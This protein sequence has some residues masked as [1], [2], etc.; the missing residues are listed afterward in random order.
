M[1]PTFSPLAPRAAAGDAWRLHQ[2]SPHWRW[3]ARLG[4][5]LPI[6]AHRH[7]R[8]PI[9]CRRRSVARRCRSPISSIGSNQRWSASRFLTAAARWPPTRRALRA[10]AGRRARRIF[11]RTARSTSS[12]SGCR[13]SS[14]ASRRPR[15]TQAQGSG[16]VI[17][18][19]GFVVTNNHVIDGANKITVNFDQDTKYEA[20]LIGTDPRTDLALLKIKGGPGNFHVS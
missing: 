20:E 18:P 11:R 1:T 7:S 6:R 10:V 4:S 15:P 17:S 19:D 8:R 14:A 5:G 2:P 3:L 12:S 16:F 9:R 13:R